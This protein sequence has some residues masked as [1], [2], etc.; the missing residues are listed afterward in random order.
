MKM[1][2]HGLTVLLATLEHAHDWDTQLPRILFGYQCGIQASMRFSSHMVLIWRT[3]KL[4][5]DNFLSPL[6]QTFDDDG[7]ITIMV[8]HMISKLQL[9][10]KLNGDFIENVNQTQ[11]QQK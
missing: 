10:V 11:V 6:V 7:E 5:V 3:P 9:I 4:K 8:E 2:K 1:L